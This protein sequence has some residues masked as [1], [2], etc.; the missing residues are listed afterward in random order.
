MRCSV[1]GPL[2]FTMQPLWQ[3]TLEVSP[4]LRSFPATDFST[5]SDGPTQ[6]CKPLLP[7]G[8]CSYDSGA[9]PL[10]RHWPRKK[11]PG[12]VMHWSQIVEGL[13]KSSKIVIRARKFWT[14]DVVKSPKVVKSSTLLEQERFVNFWEDKSRDPRI[15]NED[16]SESTNLECGSSRLEISKSDNW[17]LQEKRMDKTS[18]FTS[19]Q[20][21]QSSSLLHYG[22]IHQVERSNVERLN[23]QEVRK[24][25]SQDATCLK[26]EN[27]TYFDS[28]SKLWSLGNYPSSRGTSRFTYIVRSPVMDSTVSAAELIKRSSDATIILF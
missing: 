23:V 17:I 19:T 16:I 21:R 5:K 22:M 2:F 24:V 13:K 12:Q 9:Q 15:F 7:W 1:T 8:S 11:H 6:P 26:K 18:L 28:L 20:L 10:S 25:R 3:T 4:D 27:V 14:N